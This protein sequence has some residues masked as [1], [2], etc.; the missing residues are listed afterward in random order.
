MPLSLPASPL[1]S[2]YRPEIDGLRAIAVAAVILNHVSHGLAPGGYLG[3]DVFFAISGYVVTRSLARHDIQSA[4][5]RREFL[6]NFYARRVRRLYP[7]LLLMIV[8]VGLLAACFLQPS[9]FAY[10]SSSRTGLA[11]IWGLAN[12]QLWRSSSDY[13][14]AS[15]AHNLFTHTWSLGVEEQFYLFFPIF[16]ILVNRALRSYVLIFLIVASSI[17]FVYST[18]SDPL[19]AFYLM[20]ARFWELGAGS[21]MALYEIQFLAR[22]SFLKELWLQTLAFGLLFIA[23]LVPSQPGLTNGFVVLLTSVLIIALSGNGS[24]KSFLSSTWFAAVGV[25]SYSLYLWHWPLLLIVRA[26]IAASGDS[27][28]SSSFVVG[29]TALVASLSYWFV[30]QPMRVRFMASSSRLALLGGGA[31]SLIGSSVLWSFSNPLEGVLFLGK[32]PQQATNVPLTRSHQAAPPECNLFTA[33]LASSFNAPGCPGLL[34]P[35]KKP[36]LF[37]LGDS[38]AEQFYSAAHNYA[39]SNGWGLRIAIANSCP[40]P[41]TALAGNQCLQ[42]QRKVMSHLSTVLKKNDVVLIASSWLPSIYPRPLPQADLALRQIEDSLTNA[43]AVISDRKARVI[44]YLDGPQFLSLGELPPQRCVYEWFRTSLPKGCE[45]PVSQYLRVRQP[46]QSL[47]ARFK[48]DGV[49]IWDPLLDQTCD[50]HVCT[51]SGYID[52]THYSLSH[53]RYLFD[54]FSKRSVI[55]GAS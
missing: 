36:T 49:E 7:A 3:V 17:Y 24:F 26:T 45:L 1:V 35:S 9:D 20:P 44:L 14:S 43:V 39:H 29:L 50:R 25:L 48:G 53:A 21:L 33:D 23:F 19:S 47:F 8:V 46:L 37:I 55:F 2:H 16:W 18:L 6:S 12:L 54:R 22:F 31:M 34:S 11:A 4:T 5:P 40:F 28:W 27:F 15:V 51:P 30:E 52:G 41:P 13:F 10:Q 32:Q 38:H 42:Q